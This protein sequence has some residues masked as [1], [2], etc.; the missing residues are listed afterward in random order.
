MGPEIR[1]VG[2]FHGTW[3][4]QSVNKYIDKDYRMN[5][6]SQCQDSKS[7]GS[8]GGRGAARGRHSVS[9]PTSPFHLSLGYSCASHI[10]LETHPLP[11]HTP[12]SPNPHPLFR[13]RTPQPPVQHQIREQ[14]TFDPPP[15]ES[16]AG[17]PPYFS[18]VQNHCPRRR[19]GE[20]G[21]WIWSGGWREEE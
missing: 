4:M 14:Q 5:E 8:R 11:Y 18:Q 16:R 2:R 1:I 19:A 20:M 17:P 10:H 7:W 6:N 21:L 12:P 13:G 3:P 15:Q 9:Q